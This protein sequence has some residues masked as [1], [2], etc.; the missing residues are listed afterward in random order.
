MSAF[1][2]TSFLFA[3][4]FPRTDSARAVAKVDSSQDS[5]L[6][7]ALVRYEFQ[8]AV[9][10]KVWLQ[11]QGQPLGL[12]EIAAQTALAA[13]DL[14]LDQGLWI[15]APAEWERVLSRA[16]K[17]ANDHTPR[18]GARAMDILHLAYALELGATELLSFDGN[19][20]SVAQAE[21]LTATP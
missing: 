18:H 17:L 11:A 14:D 4:Y 12:S 8:Q 13:F 9:L 15:V 10:F 21:G 6:I 19:Q 2:D 7:S 3:F 1:A 5:P 16:E 20:R